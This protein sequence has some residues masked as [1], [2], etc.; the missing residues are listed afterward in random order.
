MKADV[1]GSSFSFPSW[2]DVS[3]TAGRSEQAQRTKLKETMIYRVL[4]ALR[5]VPGELILPHDHSLSLLL[6][7]LL[8][9]RLV[10]N[11][12]KR[13]LFPHTTHPFLQPPPNFL[14]VSRLCP[15]KALQR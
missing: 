15:Q 1:D 11:F 7:D 4:K 8:T 14:P 12:L 13:P 6:K 3:N 5:S 9:H 10:K 2:A